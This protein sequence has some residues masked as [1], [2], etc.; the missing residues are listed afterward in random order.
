MFQA[1][2][3]ATRPPATSLSD[4]PCLRVYFD[5]LR[6]DEAFLESGIQPP[7]EGCLT[8]RACGSKRIY[9]MVRQ[10]RAADEPM[11]VFARCSRCNAHWRQQ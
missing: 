1:R 4:Y 6:E 9:T 8:C 3:P 2:P 10:T 7:E 5:E 11:S